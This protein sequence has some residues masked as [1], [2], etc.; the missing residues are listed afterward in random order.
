MSK[1]DKNHNFKKGP[2]WTTQKQK[3]IE[4]REKEVKNH[5]KFDQNSKLRAIIQRQ[6]RHNNQKNRGEGGV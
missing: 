1:V 4:K 3:E 6:K 2:T 5:Q